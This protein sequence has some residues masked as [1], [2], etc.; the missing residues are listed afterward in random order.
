VQGT[1]GN[2]AYLDA[3][4][5]RQL[6]SM[7]ARVL[8]VLG[9]CGSEI[10]GAADGPPRPG[11]ARD[12]ARIVVA[13]PAGDPRSAGPRGGMANR[14]RAFP[15]FTQCGRGR[16]PGDPHARPH[17]DRL[18]A[19]ADPLLAGDLQAAVGSGPRS[20]LVEPGTGAVPAGTA[21]PEGW[22][23]DAAPPAAGPPGAKAW[24]AVRAGGQSVAGPDGT[25]QN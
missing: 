17:R 4:R 12:A 10:G 2:A 9:L 11:A 1:G 24:A 15:L 21:N 6:G 22:P 16:R 5:K 23:H 13:T 8:R 7:D 20:T 25:G 18:R 3:V 14:R 19:L